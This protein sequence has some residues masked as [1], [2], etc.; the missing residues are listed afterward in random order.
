MH[1]CMH[2]CMHVRFHADRDRFV[3]EFCAKARWEDARRTSGGVEDFRRQIGLLQL[4][5]A[6][7]PGHALRRQGLPFLQGLLH[8][9]HCG[10]HLRFGDFSLFGMHT[11]APYLSSNIFRIINR[12][13]IYSIKY[14]LNSNNGC[15]A[16]C[17]AL[18]YASWEK[19]I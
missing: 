5:T 12:F 3:S 19:M 18:S 7:V 2:A 13:Q 9:R 1:R 10:F 17:R 6:R 15:D 16:Y 14:L 4:Q 8:R 11:S